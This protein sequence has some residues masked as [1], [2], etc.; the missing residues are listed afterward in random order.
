MCQCHTSPYSSILTSV[1]MEDDSQDTSH[2][3]IENVSQDL[4]QEEEYDDFRDYLLKIE[5][6]IDSPNEGP[7]RPGNGP[8]SPFKKWVKS[9]RSRRRPAHQIPPVYVDGWMDEASTIPEET[10]ISTSP[11]T[12]QKPWDQMSGGSS[13]ILGTVKTA[14]MGVATASVVRSRTNTLTSHRSS[15]ISSPMPSFETRK[16]LDSVN[17]TKTVSME[18]AI[19]GRAV[20][21]RHV[22]R[23]ICVSESNY[24]HGL[25]TLGQVN[26]RTLVR[27]LK[28]TSV[29]ILAS[30]HLSHHQTGD[31]SGCA[32]LTAYA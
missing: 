32:K 24:V 9:F 26:F 22:L 6:D 13:S 20:K 18:N 17:L 7:L 5:R 4:S 21:R 16:S 23:E 28:L 8:N 31:S 2:N 19:R 1:V 25:Q 14:S 3:I 15:S 29:D 30:L 11:P 10:S 27:R 12:V